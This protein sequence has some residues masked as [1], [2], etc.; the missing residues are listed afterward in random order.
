MGKSIETEGRVVAVSLGEGA[1]VTVSWSQISS[2]MMKKFQKL[3]R[4]NGGPA[5]IVGI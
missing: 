4:D 3:D 5:S 1:C 2:G